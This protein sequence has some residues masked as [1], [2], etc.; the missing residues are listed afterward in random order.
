MGKMDGICSIQSD[1]SLSIARLGIKI[2]WEINEES[3]DRWVT[4]N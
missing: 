3:L 4:V 2:N 1:A